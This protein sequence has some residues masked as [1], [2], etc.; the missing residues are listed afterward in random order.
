MAK[1]VKGIVFF[2][3]KD[4]NELYYINKKGENVIISNPLISLQNR[5]MIEYIHKN[6]KHV[7]HAY[8]NKI[9]LNLINN[10]VSKHALW[11]NEN[12]FITKKYIIHDFLPIINEK[13]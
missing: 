2:N 12:R 4:N 7:S 5:E 6:A 8:G 13:N 1:G 11:I 3:N 9:T 10:R